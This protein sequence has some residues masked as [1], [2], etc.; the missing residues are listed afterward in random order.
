MRRVGKAVSIGTR[1]LFDLAETKPKWRQGLPKIARVWGAPYPFP[2]RHRG[3]KR[4]CPATL[5]FY[6]SEAHSGRAWRQIVPLEG[7]RYGVWRFRV[8]R[9]G[10]RCGLLSAPD[11]SRPC[12]KESSRFPRHRQPGGVAI[13][14]PCASRDKLHS[15]RAFQHLCVQEVC[16]GP[17][18]IPRRHQR[19]ILVIWETTGHSLLA[20]KMGGGHVGG[21]EES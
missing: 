3:A 7:G 18:A 19:S 6:V 15:L 12:V 13:G 17:L 9:L 21:V 20:G 14:E 4:S 11:R 8:Q 16:A 5:R 1:R 2:C 10:C